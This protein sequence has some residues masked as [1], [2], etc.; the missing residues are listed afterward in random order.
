LHKRCSTST[1]KLDSWYWHCFLA[2]VI[3]LLYVILPHASRT[4]NTISLCQRDYIKGWNTWCSKRPKQFFGQQWELVWRTRFKIYKVVSW[5]RRMIHELAW[6]A[7]SRLTDAYSFENDESTE[8]VLSIRFLYIFIYQT[9]DLMNVHYFEN[10]KSTELVMLDTF[11][12]FTDSNVC[13]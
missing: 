9:V 1:R 7:I 10:T 2:F 13:W 3:Y 4:F 12:V 5:L 11:S 6:M 8:L